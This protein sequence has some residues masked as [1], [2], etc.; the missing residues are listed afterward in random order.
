VFS[1]FQQNILIKKIKKTKQYLS[2]KILLHVSGEIGVKGKNRIF[3]ERKLA[4]NISKKIKGKIYRS[5]GSFLIETEK[6]YKEK[7]KKIPGIAWIAEAE[8]IER[9]LKKIKKNVLNYF[10]KNK[11]KKFNLEIKRRDK[12]IEKNSQEIRKELTNFLIKKGFKFYKPKKIFIELSK[13]WWVICRKKEKCLGGL[14]ISTS[15]RAV[16]LISGGIDSAVAS[17]LAMKKGLEIIYV[18]F[19]NYPSNYYKL[20]EDK[21]FEII[22]RLNDY[23]I[24]SKTYII[25]FSQV[26]K[27]IIKKVDAKQRYLFYKFLMLKIAERI[28]EKEKCKALITGDSLGQV[29][30]QTL[31]NISCMNSLITIPIFMPLLTYTKDEIIE[32]AKKINT[33][34]QS[35]VPYSDCC[36]FMVSKHP[37][38][39]INKEKMEKLIRKFDVREIIE[40]SLKESRVEI[41]R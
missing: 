35:I 38:T 7:L 19:H 9:D 22:K 2:M 28:A 36:T 17:F 3:F 37:C 4:K 12:N 14:P 26:Q 33:Y 21:I 30:S 32:L 13:D 8:E 31:E 41:I 10:K 6:K 29:A 40:K 23:Q 25:P 27:E 39:K 20:I 18:H 1:K 34:E 5:F 24:V 11:I 16:S 15:G